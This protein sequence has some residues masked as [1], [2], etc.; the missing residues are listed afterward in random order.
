MV[1]RFFYDVACPFAYIASTR[2]EALAAAAG[3]TVE[4]CPVL[5]GGVFRALGAP[6]DPNQQM[7]AAKARLN[8]LDIT[9]QA[10]AAGVPVVIPDAHPRRTVDA[11]RL[12]VAAPPALRPAVSRA[13]FEA[14]WVDGRDVADPAVLAAIAAAHGLEP[15]AWRDPGARQGLFDATAAFVEAGGF[16]VPSFQVGERLWWGQD[17][18]RFVAAA[19][20]NRPPLTLFHDFAS[21]FS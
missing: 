2:V 11:M 9:R 20:G 17:R 6:D 10:A 13:L 19:L 4:W 3:A 7:P 16:G 18:M 8:R 12:A 1:L 21:P 5:L 14:Y 15:E